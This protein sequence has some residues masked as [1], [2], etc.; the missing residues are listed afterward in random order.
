M[1]KTRIIPKL[2]IKNSHLIKGLQYEGLRKVGDPIVFAEKYYQEGADQ[3]NIIDIVS[4]LYS[5]DNIYEIVDKITDNI[6]IPICVGGGIKKIDHIVKLLKTGADRVII[7]SEGLR[8]KSFLNEVGNIFG[9]QF[10]SVSIEAKKYQN[11]YYC[12]MDHGRENSNIKVKEW[13]NYLSKNDVGEIIINSIDNDGME[14]GFDLSLLKICKENLNCPIVISGGAGK[15]KHFLEAA[16]YNDVDGL[17]A[18]TV[19]HFNKIKI[20]EIKNNLKKNKINIV[21]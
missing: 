17:S 9:K 10:L 16:N 11:E 8:N 4:S 15:I 6:F 18:S 7:N 5:R 20:A 21:E 12:M 19:F 13:I 14:N 1:N 2:E 3:I